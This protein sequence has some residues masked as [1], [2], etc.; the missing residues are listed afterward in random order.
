[1]NILKKTIFLLLP[2]LFIF[3][4][5]PELSAKNHHRHHRGSRTS[6]SLN[7]NMQARPVYREY[8][9]V[10]PAPVYYEQVVVANPYA[11]PVY[12]VP[13]VTS[14]PVYV[15]PAPAPL[16]VERRPSIGLSFSPS[17]FFWGS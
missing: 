8:T 17:F 5:V 1:M 9:I 15:V 3:G 12:P 11:T 4:I 6:V 7:L 10:N 16:V 14:G 2:A 13:V